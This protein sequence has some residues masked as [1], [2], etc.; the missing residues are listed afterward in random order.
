MSEDTRRVQV[1]ASPVDAA[2]SVHVVIGADPSERGPWSYI[3]GASAA[4]RDLTGPPPEYL[5]V[6][7]WGA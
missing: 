7:A 5:A 6:A 2:G 1:I 3:T 4:G